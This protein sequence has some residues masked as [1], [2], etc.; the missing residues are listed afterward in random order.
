MNITKNN[1]IL[2]LSPHTDDAELGAGGTIIKL[3]NKGCKIFWIIFSTAEESIPK[4]FNK[5]SLREEFQN[6]AEYL[7]LNNSQYLINN[8]KVRYLHEKRQ[9]IL[10]ILIRQKELINPDL[11]IGPSQNDVHQDH[12]VVS[13]E[14]IRAFK[15]YCSIISYELPWNNFNFDSRFYVRLD[16][17]TINKKITILKYYKTQIALNRKYFSEQAIIGLAAIRGSQ[18]NADYAEAF[19]VIKWID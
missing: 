19:E 13:N 10:E 2:I 17:K 9:E 7:K 1:H 16:R 15:N 3:L 4:G 11:V 5:N 18:I 14:M 12:Q 6:V 8:F